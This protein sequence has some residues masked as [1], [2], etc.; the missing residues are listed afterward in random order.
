MRIIDRTGWK[1]SML[2]GEGAWALLYP[3][4]IVLSWVYRVFLAMRPRAR[5][6]RRMPSLRNEG[7]R[8]ANVPYVVS[9]GNLEVGGGGKTPCTI[10]L[11]TRIEHGGG[12]PV[13]LSRGYGGAA[14]RRWAPFAL[15]A[16]REGDDGAQVSRGMT[17]GAFVELLSSSASSGPRRALASYVGDEIVLY[18]ERGIPVVID[19]DRA[20]GAAWARERFSP[21]HLL[22][23]DAYHL[24]SIAKD[25]DILLLDAEK[26]FGDG[27]L[28]PLGTLRET[29]E[30]ARRADVVIFTRARG[31]RVSLQA[32]HYI[33]G[34]PVLFA[35]HEPVDLLT[36]AGAPM[37]L[38]FLVGRRVVL[39]SGIV[40]PRSFEELVLSLGATV[41]TA[42]RYVDHHRYTRRDVQ[43]MLGE[44]GPDAVFVT[45]EKDWGK[46]VELFPE[47]TGVFALRVRMRIDDPEGDL[48]RL[49]HLAYPN[50]D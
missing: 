11:A 19:P 38:S 17:R 24:S 4:R 3:L 13:V 47:A 32:E 2:R 26:P 14:A 40:R 23:D 30:A 46:V 48:D 20:R 12:T 43:R 5:G 8:R 39:F 21:T 16:A 42:Y 49:L 45:T 41:D 35:A 18:H 28:L 50:V 22:L 25:L 29:P 44:S 31:P 34:K 6:R 9:I 37:P 7:S 36:R 27:R 10:S 15:P 33:E 1:L